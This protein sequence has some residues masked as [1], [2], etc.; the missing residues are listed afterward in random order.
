MALSVSTTAYF[1]EHRLLE[2]IQAIK[3]SVRLGTTLGVVVLVFGRFLGRRSGARVASRV[4]Y[5]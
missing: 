2:G 1:H 4:R 5:F 3:V